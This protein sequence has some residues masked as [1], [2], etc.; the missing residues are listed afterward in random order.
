[1]TEIEFIPLSG[2]AH[3][4]ANA[5]LVRISFSVETLQS[6]GEPQTSTVEILLDAGATSTEEPAWMEH[7]QRPDV[8]WI[9][10][11][12]W[13]HLGALPHLAKRL[14]QLTVLASVPSVST[15]R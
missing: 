15:L 7:L 9:S 13:D 3:L 2:G 12:H 4:G 11:A 10:H 8:V 1:M 5:F 14:G 6:A